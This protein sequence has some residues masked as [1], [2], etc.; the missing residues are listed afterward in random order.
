M[1]IIVSGSLAYDRIMNFS[2]YFSDHILP[3]KIKDL[4]VSFTVDGMVEKFGGTAGNIAYTLSLMG[5]RPL[6]LATIGCDYVRYFEWLKENRIATDNI[7]IIPDEFTAGAY[8]T[9]DRAD[10]QITGFN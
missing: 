9:T 3:E 7:R 5:E 8:I 2:G 6:V 10:N 1:D 4:N